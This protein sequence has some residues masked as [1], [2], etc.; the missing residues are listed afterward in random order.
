MDKYMRTASQTNI[1]PGSSVKYARFSEGL[2]LSSEI[3]L[4]S[5][6]MALTL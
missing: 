1:D 3:T 4:A 6:W 2:I 5:P